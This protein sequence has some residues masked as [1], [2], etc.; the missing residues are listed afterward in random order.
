[1]RSLT[2]FSASLPTLQ[3]AA[4]SRDDGDSFGRTR[5]TLTKDLSRS[6]EVEL[7]KDLTLASR[8]LC[9]LNL[10]PRAGVMNQQ[11]IIREGPHE[12]QSGGPSLLGRC[13]DRYGL[14]VLALQQ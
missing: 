13:L 4:A 12:R 5:K 6:G 1:M 8:E 3:L 10:L 11:R 2:L 7:P 9:G 14:T